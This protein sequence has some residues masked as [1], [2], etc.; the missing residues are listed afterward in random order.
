MSGRGEPAGCHGDGLKGGIV[1]PSQLRGPRPHPRPGAARLAPFPSAQP[2]GPS[3]EQGLSRLRRSR[4]RDWD[5]PRGWGC[6]CRWGRLFGVQGC[7]QCRLARSCWR[8]HPQV[9]GRQEIPLA[10]FI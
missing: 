6:R 10:R 2:V 1:R 9:K 8:E 4:P 5:P 3:R 7:A